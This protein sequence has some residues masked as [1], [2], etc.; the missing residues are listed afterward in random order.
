VYWNSWLNDE[1]LT[2]YYGGRLLA[3]TQMDSTT[4]RR[5]NRNKKCHAAGSNVGNYF[6]WRVGFSSSNC[7]KTR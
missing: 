6:R 7:N 4:R 3:I 5:T 1:Y 2:L